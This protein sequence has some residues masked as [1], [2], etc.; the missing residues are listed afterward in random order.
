MN[1]KYTKLCLAILASLAMA[2]CDDSND[3][4]DNPTKEPA[5]TATCGDGTCEGDETEAT[6]PKDCQTPVVKDKCGDGI[7]DIL[8]TFESCPQDCKTVCGNKIC[9]KSGG[10]SFENCKEDCDAP[11]YCGDGICNALEG[12]TTETCSLDCK[13]KI[14]CGDGTCSNGE[15]RLNCP[16][17]CPPVCG[18]GRCEDPEETE[19]NCP[20]DCE[21][22]PIEY[23]AVCGDG[24]CEEPDENSTIC[25]ADCK[26]E[27]QHDE[28]LKQLTIDEFNALQEGKYRFYFDYD[29]AKKPSD[30]VA[31]ESE[32]EKADRLMDDFFSFPFP[33]EL[34]TDEYGRQDIRY[35]PL[36][37]GDSILKLVS[38][39][40]VLKTFA[41]LIPSL[42]ERV[43]SE[44]KGFS[45][46]G[47]TYFRTTISL[48]NK[49]FP[50][51]ADTIKENSCFQMINV[52][53]D[54]RH[55]GERVPLYITYHR[56][57]KTNV[58]A[59][60]TL[61]LRPV[62]GV[63]A[64]PGDRYVTLVTNCLKSNGRALTQSNKLRY[65]LE[66][67]APDEI[68]QKMEYYVDQLKDLEAN[69]KLGFKIKDIRAMTGYQV[70]NSADEMDQIAAD[71]KGKGHINTDKNGVA[72]GEWATTTSIG[73]DV[74]KY[75]AYIF[76]GTFTT[77]NYM[78]GSYPY[79][80]KG[81]G[82]YTFDTDGKLVSKAKEESVRF[83]VILPRTEMPEKGWPIA[84]Y[85]HGT[86]GD[87]DTHCR[88][89]NDEGI[90][91]IN[92][93]AAS[94]GGKPKDTAVPMAMIG[95]DASLHG[96]RGNGKKITTPELMMMILQNPVVVRESW[97]QTVVDM[98]VLYDILDQN[99]L[100]LPP[101]PGSKDTRNVIFDNSY[102]LYMGHSQGSQEAGLL[103]GLTGSIKNAF[104]SA[105]GAGIIL[106]FVD[107][108][109]DL[110]EVKVVGPILNG[111]SVADIL[112]YILGLQDGDISY[113]SFIT[114]HIVQPL[115]DPIDPL[116]YTRRF[117]MEPPK[118]WE[119][120]NIAQTIALGDQDTPQSAQFTMIASEGLPPIGK[121]FEVT[122]P[123][124][125][126]GFT[127]STGDSVHDNIQNLD[128][129]IST[130]GT[131]QFDYTGTD[132]PHFAIYD[133][134]SARMAYVNFFHSVVVDKQ[135]KVAVS[136]NQSGDR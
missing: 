122:D 32:N 114:N 11:G 92:G 124:K 70:S 82:Q 34:R 58:W 98:L 110:S 38:S 65:I 76:R 22:T 54:S 40:P 24:S 109:P 44:R 53:K 71:L 62:P 120:K 67:A 47:A 27:E 102:G 15:T 2:S 26:P 16:K 46:I 50:E 81:E 74:S 42:V 127:K 10:E 93:G 49:T 117:V 43:Q 21:D 14:F 75:N 4:N 48:D 66:K 9:E 12:E 112:G 3:E 41:T 45:P 119:P 111:K 78:D 128:G 28:G 116:N 90:V 36:P 89:W 20:E 135:V 88:Y 103:L 85:G 5:A 18:D 123:M 105:G 130:G 52:E 63:A 6:C 101:I 72:I 68:N 115:V 69:G 84:V 131:M 7:C 13:K 96:T 132:N 51:P 29:K 118:G 56:R 121:L 23:T 113:D 57:Q 107:L 106:S 125:L 33:S 73:Y 100:I 87:S 55:Y 60:N 97:R 17:D 77:T 25:P 30:D 19:T 86:G 91:I 39:I 108:H 83:T 1:Y 99:K 64:N 79:T 104:L 126:V 134:D 80:G 136:G 35:Y 37:S 95:L 94:Y 61:V 59:S 31:G 133:M 8:E 129:K